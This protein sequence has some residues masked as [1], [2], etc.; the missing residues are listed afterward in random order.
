LP[1]VLAYI[2]FSLHFS[3]LF[4]TLE[5]SDNII[6]AIR[7]PNPSL[8][9]KNIL[10]NEKELPSYLTVNAIDGSVIDRELGY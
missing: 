3:S 4:L 7:K 9:G 6:F 8:P 10:S 5:I 1:P 2:V